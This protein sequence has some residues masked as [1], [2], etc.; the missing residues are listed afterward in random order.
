MKQIDRPGLRNVELV[1]KIHQKLDQLLMNQMTSNHPEEPNL[2]SELKKKIPDL[3]TLNTLHSEKLLAVKMD[4]HNADNGVV[5]TSSGSSSSTPNYPYAEYYSANSF[6]C[7]QSVTSDWS[8]FGSPRSVGSSCDNESTS[9]KALDMCPYSP[10]EQMAQFH[11]SNQTV[12]GQIASNSNQLTPN[13]VVSSNSS[14]S[15][16]GSSSS[17]AGQISSHRTSSSLSNFSSS[18]NH[19]YTGALA[20]HSSS[21][22][23]V[24]SLNNNNNNN[25]N[26][27]T[28]TAASSSNERSSTVINKPR[29]GQLNCF[30]N[31]LISSAQQQTTDEE[32][33]TGL[34][35]RR[36]TDSPADSGIESGKEG[37]SATSVCSSPRSDSEDHLHNNN[38]NNNNNQTSQTNKNQ[39]ITTSSSSSSVINGNS[40]GSID[41]MPMLKRAL[42]APPLLNTTSLL[43]DEAYRHHKKFRATKM[44]QAQRELEAQSP[45]SSTHSNLSTHDEL[46]QPNHSSSNQS[47]ASSHSTL[48]KTLQQQPRFANEVQLKRTDLIHTI[49]MR[50][51]SDINPSST[52][53]TFGLLDN[54]PHSTSSSLNNSLTNQ[55]RSSII[56]TAS[57]SQSTLQ[58]LLAPNKPNSGS[59][60]GS[61]FGSAPSPLKYNNNNHH[62]SPPSPSPSLVNSSPPPTGL[63]NHPSMFHY[64]STQHQL[65]HHL[66]TIYPA[67]HHH[68]STAAL[69][70]EAQPLDLSNSKKS[71]PITPPI[72]PKKVESN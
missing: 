33:L 11:L 24:A 67:H 58:Q 10:S 18:S 65:P 12:N 63:M 7:N 2:Y 31:N 53:S 48:V 52:K 46:A 23:S 47:L 38:N 43:M 14:I 32:K 42:Q 22:T 8:D 54:S 4:S 39:K 55:S 50:G 9:T 49:I 64:S 34:I 19:S 60:F 51:E 28:S 30:N 66:H 21:V 61:S 68:S 72:S 41:D 70:M 1:Q 69:L 3:R 25:N 6:K 59:I 45:Q 36:H 26:N 16:P 35:N 37:N 71:S 40:N 13:L 56:H 57:S 62:I 5:S 27:P 17:S 29:F 15:S 44:Q 20:L